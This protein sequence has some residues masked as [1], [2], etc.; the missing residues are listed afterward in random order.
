MG[1][2]MSRE[3][4]LDQYNEV[5]ESSYEF[6]AH[7]CR[8]PS[9]HQ[10]A[11]THPAPQVSVVLPRPWSLMSSRFLHSRDGNFTASQKVPG[12]RNSGIFTLRDNPAGRGGRTWGQ[13]PACHGGTRGSQTR[14]LGPWDSESR[15]HRGRG[16][17]A[18][19]GGQGVGEDGEKGTG[20]GFYLAP[21]GA[22]PEKGRAVKRV[23]AK[24]GA[25]G[26]APGQGRTERAGCRGAVPLGIPV[27]PPPPGR[28]ETPATCP[29]TSG[30]GSPSAEASQHG[31][32]FPTP[33][34]VSLDPSEHTRS[35]PHGS[36]S[37]L[38]RHRPPATGRQCE[39]A[40]G[41]AWGGWW[42]FSRFL[43]NPP[44]HLAPAV[45]LSPRVL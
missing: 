8:A 23:A 27:R 45:L 15:L 3:R 30:V 12:E 19:A 17:A 44:R 31:L 38:S 29:G 1:H 33:R 20:T 36:R 4:H 42:A 7:A 13:A 24:E 5:G 43:Q 32:A 16:E 10:P 40:S 21:A 28:S 41:E 37:C 11:A 25:G 22:R 18:E 35:V 34:G 6:P 9:Q 26:R 39:R 14:V 2:F